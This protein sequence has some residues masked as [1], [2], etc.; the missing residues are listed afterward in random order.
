MSDI[1]EMVEEMN[2]GMLRAPPAIGQRFGRLVITGE[3]DRHITKRGISLRVWVCRCDCGKVVAR[4]T[5]AFAPGSPYE[6]SCGCAKREKTI[7]RNFK[8][9][10]GSMETRP[11]EY[12]VWRAMRRRTTNRNC[13]D[14]KYYGER[15][16]KV[17]DRW[18]D[19]LVFY[20]DMGPRPSRSHSIDRIDVDSDYS[21]ENCRWATPTQQRHNQRRYIKAREAV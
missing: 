17:C 18:N 15:G 11:P 16:I 12:E 6:R 7:A 10:L 20:A 9:G 1:F 2:E 4:K 19:F 14:Y 21:P 3:A 13:P 8:H 5:A